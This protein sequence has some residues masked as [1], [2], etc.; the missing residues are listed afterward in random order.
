MSL[1]P[2]VNRGHPD[3]RAAR[4]P[5]T[6]SK[7]DAASPSATVADD[8]PVQQLDY[9][10]AAAGDSGVVGDDEE[11]G[12]SFGVQAAQQLEYVAGGL[13]IESARGLVGEHE[14]GLRN[15]CARDGDA[16]TLT[17]RQLRHGRVGATR[18]ADGAEQLSRS[19]ACFAT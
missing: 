15:Q 11:R 4:R 1:T 6:T 3:L 8:S 2:T 12:A 16:L 9:A 14:G 10:I 7:N 17:T 5:S 19:I 18:Q 13:R